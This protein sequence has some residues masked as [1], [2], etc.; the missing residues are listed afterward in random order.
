MKT[1]NVLLQEAAKA[2]FSTTRDRTQAWL[3][4]ELLLGEALKKERVWLLA[5]PDETITVSIEKRFLRL[6]ERRSQHEPL[7]YVLGEAPFYG[8]SFHVNKHTLI[9]RI[10]TEELVEKA[11]SFLK[12]APVETLI[13]DV[14][15][16]SGVIAV[17]LQCLFPTQRIL[18][19]DISKS[20]LRIAKQ[21]ANKHQPKTLP[22]FMEANLLEKKVENYLLQQETSHLVVIANLPY[23]PLKDK[24]QLQPQVKDYEPASALF[25][26]REGRALNEKLLTQLATFSKK[27]QININGCLEFDP[28]QTR[29]LRALAKE[30]FKNVRILKDL[31]GRERF[32]EFHS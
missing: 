9:P 4:A 18:A 21:N 20:A 25:A 29:A 14:G 1:I 8:R 32:L 27:H 31:H 23:I 24:D 17:T 2:L 26:A 6:L 22:I 11:R 5:H 15:T 19:T 10:E 30:H 12:T 16:G 3:E 28:S 7:A 13:W